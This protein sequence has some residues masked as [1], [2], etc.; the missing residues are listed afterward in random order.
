MKS[1]T[2]VGC[3]R[4][5]STLAKLWQDTGA[6]SVSAIFNRNIE[7]AQRARHF[8][9]AGEIVREFNE[10]QKSDVWLLSVPDDEISKT[11]SKLAVSGVLSEGNLVLHTSGIHSSANL[12]PAWASRAMTASLYPLKV[13]SEPSAA[14][15]SFDGTLCALEG[16]ESAKDILR[17]A[18]EII[19]GKVLDVQ[20]SKKPLQQAGISIIQ[21]HVTS[22]INLGIAT[23][24]RSGISHDDALDAIRPLI[25][26]VL[27]RLLDGQESAQNA[28]VAVNLS[29]DAQHKQS[30]AFKNQLPEYEEAFHILRDFSTQLTSPPKEQRLPLEASL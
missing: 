22:V 17:P 6:F 20:G 11:C 7:S 27:D 15:S 21:D 10:L 3:G 23:L 19:G 25:Y 12:G 5:G 18:I 8:V 13:I 9:G 24:E 29:S 14:A 2:V 26:P 28:Q 30:H 4:V 16:D 1:L